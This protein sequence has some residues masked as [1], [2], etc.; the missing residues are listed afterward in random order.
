MCPELCSL[1][2]V[3][4]QNCP[5]YH[6]NKEVVFHADF[7]EDVPVIVKGRN[8]DIEGESENKKCRRGLGSENI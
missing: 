7:R 1:N 5:T 6:R 3:K 4:P 8:L 2:T